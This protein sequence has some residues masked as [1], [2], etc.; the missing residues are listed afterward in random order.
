M[1]NIKNNYS[2]K[3]QNTFKIDVKTKYF[4]NFN[5]EE[6]LLEL[7]SNKICKD[8]TLFILGE[9]SNIL[10]TKDFKGIVLKNKIKGINILSEDKSSTTIS[11]GAGENWHDFVVWSIKNNLSGIE[12][13]A[14]IPGLVG[15]SP[16]QN[17]GAYGAEV[18]D[19]ITKVNYIE[20]ET[21]IR[22][23]I[24]NVDCK[25][26]YRSS[27]FKKQLKN[28]IVITKVV[29]KLSKI[30]QTNILYGAINDE[31][32]HLKKD[33]SPAAI[34]EAVINI[35]NS[36]LPDPKI[37]GNSGSFFKNPII[38]IENFKKLK[39]IFPNIIAYK[40]S[41][42]HTKLAA[43]WLIEDLGYKGYQIGDAGV[44]KDQAL[45]LVNHGKASGQEILNLANIIKTKVK[46][47]YGV[48]LENEVNIL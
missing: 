40:V 14:L 4:A 26:E 7:L 19:V 11:V 23:E 1:S 29:Y 30:H 43:G 2:L 24:N 36:K 44:H 8:E 21:G 33:P 35:R 6:E 13:L 32:K 9:G 37:L 34:A 22:K 46:E 38:T 5:S 18:K 45:V 41:N 12:N 16:I 27:I 17:I 39:N 28:K 48:N 47:K 20:I 25:F 15:A 31:L 10:F 3:D 42:T